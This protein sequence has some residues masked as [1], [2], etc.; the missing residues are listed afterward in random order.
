VC[1]LLQWKCCAVEDQGWSAY[2][3]SAWYQLQPG[4]PRRYWLCIELLV[5][6]TTVPRL[7]ILTVNQSINR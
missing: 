5:F 7:R 3:T 6:N 4:T 1:V 2:R